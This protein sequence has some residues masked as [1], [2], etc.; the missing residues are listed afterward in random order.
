MLALPMAAFTLFL[1]RELGMAVRHA[2]CTAAAIAT[3]PPIAG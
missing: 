3:A 2:A 1:N